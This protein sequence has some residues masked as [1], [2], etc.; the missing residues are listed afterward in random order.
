MASITVYNNKITGVD[1]A[2]SH[3]SR[4]KV[5][6]QFKGEEFGVT[7]F[8]AVEFCEKLGIEYEQREE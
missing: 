4:D 3:G 5:Q 7:M 1:Y 8:L 6:V 2:V